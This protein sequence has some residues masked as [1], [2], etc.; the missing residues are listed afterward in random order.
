MK[1]ILLIIIVIVVIVVCFGIG[2]G[3]GFGNGKGNGSGSVEVEEEKTEEEKTEEVTLVEE[4]KTEIRVLLITVVENDYFYENERI[5]IEDFV[6]EIED[7][8]DEFVVEI[9]DDKASLKAYNKL[10]DTLDEMNVDYIESYKG[11]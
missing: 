8:E 3:L 4:S 6:K 9:K 2:C 7:I 10:L 11:K 5:N 1:K